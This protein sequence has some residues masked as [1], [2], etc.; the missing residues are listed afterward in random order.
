MTNSQDNILDSNQDSTFLKVIESLPLGILLFNSEGKITY[1]NN[2]FLELCVYHQIEINPSNTINIFEVDLFCNYNLTSHLQKLRDGYS[3]ETELD[4]LKSFSLRKVV[5]LVRGI[6]IFKNGNFD[7]GILILEDVK[8]HKK[9]DSSTEDIESQW[10]EIINSSVDILLITDVKGSIKFSFGKKVK[11]FLWRI[12]PFEQNNIHNLFPQEVV[13]VIK[14]N[15]NRIKV[16]I[17]SQKFNVQ[18]FIKNRAFDYECEIEPILDDEKKVQ[19]LFFKFR[20]ISNFIKSLKVLEHKLQ[21]L[22][23]YK[24]YLQKV[25]FP[26][27]VIN[28]DGIITDWNN[29][30]ENL[31]GYTEEQVKENHFAFLIGIAD[32]HFFDKIKEELNFNRQ[33]KNTLKIRTSS[34]KEESLIITFTLVEENDKHIVISCEKVSEK[35]RLENKIKI[36]ENRLNNLLQHPGVISFSLDSSGKFT[37]A[38]KALL[39]LINFSKEAILKKTLTE[40]VEPQFLQQNSLEKISSDSKTS[41]TVEI[42]F[43]SQNKNK[44]YVAGFLQ[45]DIN[46]NNQISYSGYFQDVTSL[47][48]TS[49]EIKIL[50]SMVATAK[51]GILIESDNKIILT[52]NSFSKA[53]GYHGNEDLLGKSFIEFVADED[54]KRISEYLH[55]LRRKMDAPDRFEFLGKKEDGSTIFFSVSVSG[56]EVEGKI[57]LTY[58]IRDIT[59]RRH[60]QFTLRKSEEEYRNLIENIDD[61]FYSYSKIK[62]KLTP[63]FYSVNVQ[64]I[65]GYDQDQLLN[66]QKLFFKIV[67]P[68]DLHIAKQ[69]V[70]D[71]LKSR[72][73]NSI[74]IEFRIIN[75]YGNVVWV[76]NK[77]NLNRDALGEII[78]LF[79]IV[80]DISIRKKAED[81]LKKS[82]EDLVKMN[83]TKDRFLSIVSH[84]LRTPFSSILGFTDL[85]LNDNTLEEKELKQYVK[86]IRESSVSMLSLVN[87]LLDWN[88]IQSGRIQ[89]EPERTSAKYIVERSI[90]SVIGAAKQKNIELKST[91]LDEIQIFVDVNLILQVF[92]NLIS[93]AI[94]FTETNGT[95]TVSV[96]PSEHLRFLEFSVKDTGVG[97]KKEDIKKLF[98]IDVKF[99]KDG[100]AGEKGSGIGLTIVGDIIQRHGGKIL[101][102]SEPGKGSDFKFTLPIASAVI[103]LVDDNKTDRLLYS[104]ILNHITPD[105]TIEVASNGREAM[106]KILKS[107]PALVITDHNMPEM[108]GIQLVQEIQKLET[109]SKSP[110]MVLS[111]D[112]D[113]TAIHDY[114]LLGIDYIF[115]KPVNLANFKQAVERTIRKGLLGE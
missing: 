90:N 29:A 27:F 42:P 12:S 102:E 62:G 41:K 71:L 11:K 19:L 85:I 23:K 101:V 43:L 74:E 25:A 14:E 72:I 39:T 106:N 103:L 54:V 44:I 2:N 22:S 83:E 15:I 56:F 51:D 10:K 31:F 97:I 64:R 91:I 57:Y 105:Y 26:A 94:K 45:K 32:P 79:G 7:G 1:L 20:D 68:D 73:K 86:F 99:T 96:K 47:R 63:V 82:K 104:K 5:I 37:F 9:E 40:I 81:E 18:L 98:S 61:F 24:T 75:K 21:D 113:R 59:E 92:N 69:K 77:I 28:L 34:G 49:D 55:L 16:D 50:T 3:F 35:L 33:T 84:D 70:K 53:L 115:Q 95:I 78:N 48:K 60:A 107:P 93:N 67:H 4:E 112:I 114:G 88:R 36:A 52:N 111:G 76:R 100:T 65:T 80:S 108:N 6:P 58:I 89:F 38:N 110:I 30:S 8:I 46:P 17:S 66:D 109:K 13:S 87:S